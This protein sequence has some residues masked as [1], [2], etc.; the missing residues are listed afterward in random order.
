M[1]KMR[2]NVYQNNSKPVYV[3]RE[4]HGFTPCGVGRCKRTPLPGVQQHNA[5]KNR[6]L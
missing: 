5:G 1:P 6:A 4:R 2:L 3:Q